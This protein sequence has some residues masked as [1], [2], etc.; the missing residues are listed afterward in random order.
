MKEFEKIIGYTDIKQ[1][2]IQIADTFK[3]REVYQKLGIKSP[4]G[5]LL[6]GVP[7]VGKTLM[8]TS[9]IEA[10][11]LNVV[12][13]RKDKPNGDFVNAI[14]EAFKEAESISPSIIFLDD[15]DKFTNGDY[16][17][18]DAEEYVTIQSCIDSVKGK[19]VFVLA[20]ANELICLP[21]SLLRAGR[22]DRIIPVSVPDPIDAEK[23]IAY[24]LSTKKYSPLLD[25]KAIARVMSGRSCAELETI[26]N[27][28]GI[29]AGFERSEAITTEHFLKASLKLIFNIPISSIY[30]GSDFSDDPETL[31]KIAYHEAGHA[32]IHEIF[33]PE[34]IT[35]ITVYGRMHSDFG[36]FTSFMH[37]KNMGNL[38][39]IKIE[40]LAALAGMATLEQKF[41]FTDIG[42][43]A[44][45]DRAFDNVRNLI[46]NECTSGFHLHGEYG[47]LSEALKNRQEQTIAAEVENYYKKTK[48]IIASNME[49]LD[50]VASAL[51]EKKLLSTN[52]L[53]EIKAKHQIKLPE[54]I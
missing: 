17:H 12:T 29:Y 11:G 22:F 35:L 9:L 54:V 15:M 5:L 13:C 52:A 16:N 26:I 19:N 33:E 4:C 10:S 51:I 24:Y 25:A 28:A 7:G 50:A 18:P 23:I 36:G 30:S 20:T 21:Q 8:A 47:D 38:K 53:Q 43:S 37:N 48:A 49:F 44:D 39:R 6:H 1:E 27:E 40:I 31:E 14:R 32:I 42:A 3:N 41:G 2:L 45:L 34:S 46:I